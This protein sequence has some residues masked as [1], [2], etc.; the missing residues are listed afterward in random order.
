M[1]RAA[2]WR[3]AKNVKAPLSPSRSALTLEENFV[4]QSA[5]QSEAVNRSPLRQVVTIVETSMIGYRV[6]ASLRA[7]R[8]SSRAEGSGRRHR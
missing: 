1:R 2:V 6:A 3:Q 8:S 7:Q 5:L 4:L